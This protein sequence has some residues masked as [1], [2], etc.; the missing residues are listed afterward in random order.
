[1]KLLKNFILALALI[2]IIALVG[3][4][5]LPNHY[6]VSNSIEINKP[7]EVVYVQV[8]DF[9][10]W[11]AWSPWYEQEKEAAITVENT[12]A[13]TGH[14]MNWIGKKLGEGSMTIASAT[15]NAGFETNDD[16]IKPFKATAKDRFTFEATATGTKVTWTTEGGLAYPMGRLF[17]LA[18][19][20][21][22]GSTEKHGLDNL[23]K[24]CEAFPAP[25]TTAIDSATATTNN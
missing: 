23:K 11:N 6:S 1:M 15:S 2:S 22:V 12:P 18:V 19:D 10:K 3:I 21:M 9:N 25:Q 24:I 4:Y 5:F 20:K 8:A 16:F 7:V 14:K 17:G 13:A